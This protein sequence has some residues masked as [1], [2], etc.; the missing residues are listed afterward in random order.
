MLG[1]IS[2]LEFLRLLVGAPLASLA[3]ACSTSTEPRGGSGRLTVTP[4]APTIAAPAGLSALG[5]STGRD[6]WLYVPQGYTPT[7]TWPLALF[8]H[9]AITPARPYVEAFAPFADAAGL[10]ILAPDSR[11]STWDLVYGGFGADIPFIDRAIAHTFERVAVDAARI[12][13]MGFS[14]GGSYALSLGVTNGDVARRLAA[15]APGFLSFRER[16][17]SP[18]VRIVHGT[19]DTVLP[20]QQTGRPITA[21]LRALGY[22]VELREFDGGHGVPLSIVPDVLHWLAG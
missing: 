3:G 5:L 2:R 18:P 6:G 7:R 8:F 10:V 15:F 21:E 9:G 16:H 4:T 13:I 14:D 11:Q 19:N 1:S 17:G 20:L 12:G 22:S